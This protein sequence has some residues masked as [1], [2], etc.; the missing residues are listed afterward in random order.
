MKRSAILLTIALTLVLTAVG[1]RAQERAEM[2][3]INGKIW[4]V[5]EKNPWAEAIAVTGG[6]I[7]A[8][9][10]YSDVRRH[11]GR[12]TEVLDVEGAFVMPGFIDSHC[13]F[14]GGGQR[15]SQLDLSRVFTIELV[16]EILA[17]AVAEG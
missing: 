13:H 15:L 14:S 1:V 10:D 4:T 8:I 7:I 6:R 9:G 5:D 2:A 16:Q 3:I 12:R 11:I 17:A